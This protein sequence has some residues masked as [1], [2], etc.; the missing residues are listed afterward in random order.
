MSDIEL[1]QLADTR[2]TQRLLNVMDKLEQHLANLQAV[3]AVAPSAEVVDGE[4]GRLRKQNK[5]LQARQKVALE[6]LDDLLARMDEAMPSVVENGV[7]TDMRME[8]AA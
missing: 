3:G 6:R 8:S 7:A 5:M 4:I 2:S 1:P